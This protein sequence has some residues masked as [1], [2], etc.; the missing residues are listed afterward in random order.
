[1]LV[2]WQLIPCNAMGSN[3]F[4]F[5]RS[6]F[7]IANR[8]GFQDNILAD[9]KVALLGREVGLNKLP[10]R[11]AKAEQRI[12]NIHCYVNLAF[13]VGTLV[14]GPSRPSSY[15]ARKRSPAGLSLT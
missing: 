10:I 15:S 4:N 11:T 12:S 6:Y 3:E 1:M 5:F 13:L 2:N 8:F 7:A 9:A 14:D